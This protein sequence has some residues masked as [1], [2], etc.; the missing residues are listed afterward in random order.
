MSQPV[1][2]VI[3]NPDWPNHYQKMKQQILKTIGSTPIE[4]IGSTS[5]LGLGSKPIIDIM[6]ASRTERKQTTSNNNWK[7]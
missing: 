5:V 3:P 6:G 7:P 4:H 1:R 2:I